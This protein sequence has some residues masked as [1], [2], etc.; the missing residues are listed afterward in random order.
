MKNILKV[1]DK[2]T[3]SSDGLKGTVKEAGPYGDEPFQVAD[4]IGRHH[5]FINEDGTSPVNSNVWSK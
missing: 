4:E 5:S 1:G 2:V 3:R